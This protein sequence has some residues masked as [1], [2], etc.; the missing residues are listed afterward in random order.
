MK[1]LNRYE[2]PS[3]CGEEVLKQRA[4][5][6]P[7]ASRESALSADI[8][9]RGSDSECYVALNGKWSFG[10]F[11]SPLA[12]PQN[13]NEALTDTVEVPSCWQS[14]EGKRYGKPHYTNINYPFPFDPP[15]VPQ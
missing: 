9:K 6:V 4:Y 13:L 10:Y 5:Y 8:S 14:S 2:N 11:E 7:Y 15:F 3:L 12:V 1:T